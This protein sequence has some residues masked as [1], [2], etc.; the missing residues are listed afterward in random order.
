MMWELLGFVFVVVVL[1]ELYVV[2]LGICGLVAPLM[3]PA[4]LHAYQ[5]DVSTDSTL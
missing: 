5:G 4:G 1:S 2:V 3:W